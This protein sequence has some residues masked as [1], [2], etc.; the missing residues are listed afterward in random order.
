MGRGAGEAG[1][2]RGG[3]PQRREHEECQRPCRLAIRWRGHRMTPTHAIKKGT[4]YRYYVSRPLISESRADAVDGLRIPAGDLEQLVMS[5]IG[6]FL[7]EPARVSE[8]LAPHAET[9]AQQRH[10]LHRAAE[11]A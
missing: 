1:R 6:Q 9:A 7:S 4:R 2:Q 8:T 3:A 5:R 11:L 10:M